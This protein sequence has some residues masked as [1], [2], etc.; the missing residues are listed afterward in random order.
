[1][2]LAAFWAGLYVVRQSPPKPAPAAPAVETTAARA[3]TATQPEV[4]VQPS[5][6]ARYVVQVSSYGTLEKANEFK[7]QLKKQYFAAY[8]QNPTKEDPLYHVSIGPYADYEQAKQLMNQLVG[9]GFKG[10][11]IVPFKSE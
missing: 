6:D 5:P 11:M 1:M 2:L 8:T 4:P 10:V 9:Q 3:A 7:A